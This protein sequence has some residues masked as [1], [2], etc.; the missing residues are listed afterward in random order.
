MDSLTSRRDAEDAVVS[1]FPE[2]P[3]LTSPYFPVDNDALATCVSVS[4][5]PSPPTDGEMSLAG[6]VL[7]IEHR[8]SDQLSKLAFSHP[9]VCVYDPLS[10]AWQP[11][12]QYVTKFVDGPK[13]ILFVG[14][15]PGPWGMAQTG[16][17]FGEV[18][19]VQ[20]WMGIV[21]NVGRPAVEHPKRRIE[22]FQCARSEVSG[23]RFWGLFRDVAGPAGNFFR[24]CFVYSYCPLSFMNATGRNITPPELKSCERLALTA[25]CDAALAEIVEALQVDVVIGV[26]KF[27]EYRVR[28]SLKRAAG[29]N[30]KVGCLLHPSPINPSANKGW[31]EAALKYLKEMDVLHLVQGTV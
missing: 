3:I 4:T 11:H 8:L 31:K 10:Y 1:T 21:A 13:P 7:A 22:G 16:I 5:S 19:I 26:G 15:N 2:T 9:V 24:R 17:P 18:R 12:S 27:A 6:R 29:R 23:Q 30:V 14:M 25:L 28:E 20:D